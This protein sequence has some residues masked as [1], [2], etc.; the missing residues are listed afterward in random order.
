MQNHS[1][2]EKCFELCSKELENSASSFEIKKLL[3]FTCSKTNKK[4]DESIKI[5]TEAITNC[6]DIDCYLEVAQLQENKNP[7]ESLALY[8]KLLSFLNLG[9]S[10]THNFEEKAY[11]NLKEIKPEL[12]INIASL[13]LRLSM[14]NVNIRENKEKE[15][16]DLAKTEEYLNDALKIVKSFLEKSDKTNNESEEKQ[17]NIV[18][19]VD[20][21]DGN[22]KIRYKALEIAIYYNLGIYNEI[23]HEFGEAYCLYKKILKLN[24][25]FSEAYLKLG[26]LAK[27]R[28]NEKKFND[29]LDEAILKHYQTQ[30]AENA[31]KEKRLI[32]PS[33]LKPVNPKLIK[34]QSLFDSGKEDEALKI[35]YSI[36]E[37]YNEKDCYTLILLGNI[38]YRIASKFRIGMLPDKNR[39]YY[40][41]NLNKSLELYYKA[42][43]T[44]KYNC[45]AAIGIANVLA[46]YNLTKESLDIYKTVSDVQNNNLNATV[47]EALIYM[48]ENQFEKAIINLNKILKKNFNGLNP[49]IEV[50]LIKCYRDN[51]DFEIALKM[52]KSLMFRYPDNLIYKIN[53]ALTLKIQAEEILGKNERK[54]KETEEAIKNLDEAIPLF[55]EITQLK[56]EVKEKIGSELKIISLD[57]LRNNCMEFLG[58]TKDTKEKAEEILKNDRIQEERALQKYIENKKKLEL[59]LLDEKRT[60]EE[61]QEAIRKQHDFEEH[62]QIDFYEKAM[63]LKNAQKDTTGKRSK[64]K[65]KKQ[66][67]IIDDDNNEINNIEYDQGGENEE[68]D[69]VPNELN[70]DGDRD[71][72]SEKT[73]KTDDDRN[74]DDTVVDKKK[75]TTLYIN[76]ILIKL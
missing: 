50:I 53:Y 16:K 33:L 11:E 35:A 73:D 75:V 22:K 31:G 6:D 43:E 49:E 56:R 58:Y 61:K 17:N 5:L 51:K 41:S 48:N 67:D 29:Y 37:Q 65:K 64:G 52:L 44:D 70:G 19:T 20:K 55:M 12:L 9:E 27:L 23:K 10:E 42:L 39:T 13:K 72:V 7:T 46:E 3:A 21:I 26:E 32:F 74:F 57:F 66:D 1:E 63:E 14:N 15:A 34:I 69:Y 54:V 25:N 28:G 47:N 76:Y 24:P 30:T 8:E 60:L 2:A 4:Q 71:N 68:G 59:L 36:L 38:Y 45:Y 40:N 18:K 62:L